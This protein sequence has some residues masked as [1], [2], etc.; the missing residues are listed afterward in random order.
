MSNC[1]QCDRVSRSDNALKIHIGKLH[2]MMM[3][4]DKCAGQRWSVVGW[5]IDR[6]LAECF[7]VGALPP[8]LCIR[9]NCANC[10]TMM[11]MK[12]SSLVVSLEGWGGDTSLGEN[13]QRM[14]MT[15][16]RLKVWWMWCG[17]WWVAHPLHDSWL[18]QFEDCRRHCRHDGE[19][20]Q[21]LSWPGWW[22]WWRCLYR[23]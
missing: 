1:D 19:F 4:P 21:I 13:G 16:M 14:K 15:K 20:L 6:L 9:L 11:M 12:G 8:C 17:Q 23:L 7:A 22:W 10:R 2:K 18:G 3:M 5:V